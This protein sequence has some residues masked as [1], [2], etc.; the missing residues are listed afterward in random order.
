MY[1][2]ELIHKIKKEGLFKKKP[3][4]ENLGEKYPE[5]EHVF[6]PVDST[7]KVLACVKCGILKKI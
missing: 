3:E 7:K 5:C 4:K 6:V 2:F 1:I